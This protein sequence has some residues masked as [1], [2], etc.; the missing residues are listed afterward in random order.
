MRVTDKTTVE[1]IE[2]IGA[3]NLSYPAA[4]D[5]AVQC[6]KDGLGDIVAIQTV[7][8]SMPPPAT[9]TSLAIII[10]AVY[11]DTYWAKTK[12]DFTILSASLQKA[13]GWGQADCN[14]AAQNA[15]SNWY[16]VLARNDFSNVGQIPKAGNLTNSPDAL[17]NMDGPLIRS[18]ILTQWNSYFFNQGV[19]GKNYCYGR[20]QS[21]N[22]PLPIEQPKTRM[23]FT[24]AGFNSPPTSW[25]IMYTE[26][27]DTYSPLEG[28]QPGPIPAGGRAASGAFL[29]EPPAAKHYCL[30]AVS[31]TEFFTNDPLQGA[32]N[33]SSQEW[34]TRN[35]AAAWH[36]IDIPRAMETTLKFYNQDSQP[37]RFLFE[38]HCTNV[39]TGTEVSLE[40]KDGNLANALTSGR[41]K[42]TGK[43]HLVS[44]GEALLPAGFAGDVTVRIKTPNDKP[45]PANASVEV[46]MV[47]ILQ[48]GHPHYGQAVDQL[49]A[50]NAA[51][52]AQPVRLDLGHFTFVGPTV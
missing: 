50:H 9:L 5:V 6:K 40:C 22:I 49:R 30:L 34:I 27:K 18:T 8:D 21:V 38:A 20:V 29:F 43:H 36:N 2:A 10:G 31:A 12:M 3:L 37:E 11:A 32:G 16:G 14:K 19:V 39:P 46:R 15:F 24:D 51:V 44:T 4:W 23:F 7:Y 42:V 52:A 41:V 45:L 35:G 13:G 33:W 17:C 1:T 47:W 48:P 26:K 28:M 25:Q